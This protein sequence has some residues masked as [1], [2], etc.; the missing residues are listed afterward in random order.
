VQRKDPAYDSDLAWVAADGF[1]VTTDGGDPYDPTPAD[2]I[3][4]SGAVRFGAGDVDPGAAYR[5]LVQEHEIYP[6]DRPGAAGR[7]LE[8]P[9]R[10]PPIG[11]RLVYAETVPLDAALLGAPKPG[12]ASTTV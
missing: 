3:L 6:A 10:R 7:L 2:F 5:L 12:A 9:L 11:T 8:E 4:W 1:T